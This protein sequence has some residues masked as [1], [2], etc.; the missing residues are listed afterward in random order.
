MIHDN[1]VTANFCNKTMGSKQLQQTAYS[2]RL[3]SSI[4]F[5]LQKRY[6]QMLCKLSIAE[7]VDTMLTLNNSG[8]QF[9]NKGA[10]WI[11]VAFSDAIEFC[12]STQFVEQFESC[13][14]VIDDGQCIKILLVGHHRQFHIMVQIGDTLRHRELAHHRLT[15]AFLAET[16]SKLLRMVDNSFN[17]QR[18]PKLV[19]H[20]YDVTF[21]LMFNPRPKPSLFIMV[22]NLYQKTIAIQKKI[23]CCRVFL[24]RISFKNQS[25]KDQYNTCNFG[26]MFLDKFLQCA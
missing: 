20:F 19:V 15:P 18:E 4:S 7:I 2:L 16:D 13:S 14:R 25:V 12:R 6:T 5:V 22:L 8:K 26:L 3:T 23:H 17:S 24:G 10:D 21:H 9:D 1:D 11:H